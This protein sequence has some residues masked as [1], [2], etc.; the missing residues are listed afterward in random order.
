MADEAQLR[1]YLKRVTIELAEERKRQHAF[2]HEPVAIVGMACRYPGGAD[3]PERLWRLVAEGRDAISGFPADRGWDLERLYDLD[4]AQPGT[5]YAREGGFLEDAAGFDAGFFGI[6]PREALATDPQQRLLLEVSWEALER[7]GVDP[8][9]LRG[10][11]AGVFAGLMYH[12][13]G[14]RS[15]DGID[16]LEGYFATGLAGSVASGRIAYSLGLEGPAVTLDTACSSSLVAMHLAAQALRS[17]E[18]TLALAGGA[19]VLALPGAFTEL[20]RQR[21]LAPDGR[22]KSFAEAADGVGWAEGAGMLVLERLSD[23]QA[24]GRPVLATIRGSAVNQDGASNGLSSPNGPSQERVIRQ[25]LAN[26]RLASRDV[27]AV[28]AHGTGTT[29]GDPIEA[30][31]LLATYGQD[32]ER[33]LK[34]GSIKS[35]IGHTQA[36]AGVAGVIKTVMAMREGV[37]PKTLHVDEPSS[38]VDWEAGEIELLTEAEPWQ[39]NDRPRRVGVSSFGVSGTNAHVILEEAPLSGDEDA[40]SVA[41]AP[42]AGPT[43]LLLSARSEQAL[44]AQ[45][46]RLAA[47]MRENAGL[48]PADLAWSLIATRSLFEHRAA[49]VGESR[50]QLLESLEAL[51]RGEQAPGAAI[52]RHAPGGAKLAYLFTGQGSQRAGMG[53]GLYGSD[54]AFAEALDAVCAELERSMD[55]PLKGLLFAEPGSA[56]AALLDH[57]AYAQPALFAIEVAL[58][59]SL[60][61]RGLSPDLLAG[62]S[63]G[64]IA[65]AHVA[66]VLSL[67]DAAKLVVARGRL[68]GELPEG[69]AMVAIEAE[70][71]ELGEWLAGNEGDLAIAAINGPRSTVLSGA[72]GPIELAQ[73]DWEAR[74]R[75]A[76]RLA[77]SHAFHSPLIDPMLEEFER[78]A[79]GLT[80]HEPKLPI[81]S[82]VSGELLSAEQAVDPRYWVSQ[83]R[84]PVRFADAVATLLGEGATAFLEL[85]PD[86]VLSAMAVNCLEGDEAGVAVISTLRE[87]REEPAALIAALAAAHVA[88]VEV[89]WEAFFDGTGAKTVPLPTY[90]FQRERYWLNPSGS[91]DASSIGLTGAEHPLLGAVIV[92]PEGEG[93]TLTGRISLA[94]LPWLAD[95]AIAGTVLLPGTAF[96]EL[97]LR[98]GRESACELVEE[99]TLLAPLILPE[100]GAAQIQ[101]TV[102]APGEEG[103]REVSIHSRP[104]AGAEESGEWTCHARGVLSAEAPSPIEPIDSWP[105]EGAEPLDLGLLYDRLVELGFEYGPA[106]QGLTAA[107][108]QGDEMYGEVSLASEHAADGERFL[109][110]PVLLDASAH[111]VID[112]SL[113]GGKADG[114]EPRLPFAWQGVRVF[115]P[116]RSSLRVRLVFGD[117]RGELTAVD[118]AGNPVAVVGSLVS[119]PI[120]PAMLRAAT[121]RALPLHRP[122]W[123]GIDPPGSAEV[124]PSRLALIGGDGIEGLEAER[125]DA[126]SDLLRTIAAGAAAPDLLL[127][128]ERAAAPAEALP[129]SAHARAQRGLAL[130]QAFL[131]A[132]GLRGCRLCLLTSG[133]VAAGEGEAPDLASAPLWGLLRSAHSEH[134]GRFSL[135]D[136]DGTEASLAALGAALAVTG[137]L[138][139]A[140]REGE[141]VAPRLARVEAAEE[142]AGGSIDPEHT[143]LITGGT[144]G[145]GALLARR[146]VSEHGARHL[147]LAGRRG[148]EAP[149]VGELTAEL[150]D[151]GASVT[152]AACDVADRGRLEEL[153]GSIPSE[154]PLGAVFHSAGLI[155]DGLIDSLDAE[156]LGR[157][158]RPKVDAAWHLHELTAGAELS[159]FVLFSSAAGVLGGAA[160]ANYAAA[161]AF[162][163][164]LAAHRRAAGLPASALAWGL[165]GYLDSSALAGIDRGEADRLAQ[166]V[167]ERL[168]LVPMPAEQGLALLDAALALDAAQL[169]PAAFDGAVLRAQATAGTLPAILRGLVR[170]PVARERE[171]GSLAGRLAGVPAA[172][173]EAVVLDLVRGHV[174]AVLGHSSAAK[175]DPEQVFRDLGFDSLAAVELRNRLAAATGLDL[176]PT[177][178]F[179]YP[180]PAAVVAHLLAMVDP[181]GAGGDRDE[182]A[183]FRREL[184]RLPLS[185]LRDAGLLEPLRKLVDADG[186]PAAADEL[187]GEIDSMD[188]EDLVERTLDR[189][190]DEAELGAER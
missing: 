69:G 121:R 104:E 97:A 15:N 49:V 181:E 180:S 4:P 38:K 20:S 8:H 160:Q 187:L 114:L 151:G 34:L 106:F 189:Q 48:D 11:S 80:Y 61:H 107:W 152:V 79:S 6:G 89:E 78:I 29:L 68:M 101:V 59:R 184:A 65:A 141:L 81:V 2:R 22:C 171:A 188:L 136:A 76:K 16:E 137:E 45:A 174:A 30:G 168:G 27:D 99:L 149:G 143:V 63:V 103:S 132:E 135:V 148:R 54:P 130:V 87:G 82:T 43:P 58:H 9:S 41:S 10:S 39:P 163:D 73:A 150:E 158:M 42:A 70:E 71:Q 50:E 145:I 108:R 84:R 7:A 19:T 182:E 122:E 56:E 5:S 154:H 118:E 92:D 83:A 176:P 46:G 155:D 172:D 166:Q 3:D 55:R 133:A 66:G 51:R 53:R 142:P 167:R 75:K 186:E 57:T 185:R 14:T 24:K 164:A 134:P 36:A 26:A 86:A 156:R 116:G 159:A 91:A 177:L 93:L 170:V 28:E 94:D 35:N 90:P 88:G 173:R 138:Q 190:E 77:V 110:H 100:P 62:H 13:Y 98:A 183:G 17:G 102:S 124:E 123:I 37:L 127:V 161:N 85:G 25:A 33:P 60:E 169:V 157:V 165:W 153:L 52:G 47:H 72:A 112:L 40:A 119:R 113:G 144:G 96:L 111:A 31:A 23:A 67:P 64:E 125:Y 126:L 178:V 32:R 139:L 115:S 18:C 175:I 105:P 162:L 12:D 109:M 140:L 131:G 128:D 146:L 120:D 21:G 44:R 179:D 74:R 129:A 1:S 117:G 95:H 147:L